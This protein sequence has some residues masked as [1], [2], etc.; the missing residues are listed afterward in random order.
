MATP[1][2]S[3]LMEYQV[4]RLSVVISELAQR[5]NPFGQAMQKSIKGKPLAEQ[6]IIIAG[7]YARMYEA[8]LCLDMAIESDRS[9]EQVAAQLKKA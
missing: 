4:K 2:P 3:H 5:G 6:R 9:A 1:Q 8:M 7:S